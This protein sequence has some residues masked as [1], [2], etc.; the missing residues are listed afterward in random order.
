MGWNGGWRG[1]WDGNWFGDEG[2]ATGPNYVYAELIAGGTGS[3]VLGAEL[4][5]AAPDAPA[6]NVIPLRRIK[7]LRPQP[8]PAYEWDTD[9]EEALLLITGSL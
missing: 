6:G 5:S 3:A 2:G 8:A 1:N 7:P 9:E 4:L